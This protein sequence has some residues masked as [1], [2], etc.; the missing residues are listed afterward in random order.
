MKKDARLYLCLECHLQVIICSACDHGNIYC[1]DCAPA[2]RRDSLRAAGKRYQN[3]PRGRLKHAQRQACYRALH[4][5]KVTHHPSASGTTAVS[6]DMPS[7]GALGE[8][9]ESE[10]LPYCCHFCG[11]Q[12][13]DVLRSRAIVRVRAYRRGRYWAQGP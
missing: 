2:A 13:S 10:P 1:V 8:I 3:T 5:Q 4:Q 9:S 7:S 11:E 6:L 12:C